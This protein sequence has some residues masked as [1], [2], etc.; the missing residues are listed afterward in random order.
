M[1]INSIP[2]SQY[3][4]RLPPQA[5]LKEALTLMLEK[6]VNHIAICEMNGRYVGILSTNAILHTLIPASAKVSGGLSSLR[7][8]GDAIRL[9]TAHLR[10][11]ETHQVGQFVNMSVPVMREDDPILEA[12]KLLADSST[13]LPVIDKNGKFV[14]VL[15]RR[16]L[17]AYLLANEG[18][19]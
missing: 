6:Q 13:P 12:A 14:G 2:I 7:F 17:L 15:S 8:T 19:N 10:D 1:P 11:L 3:G 5:S 16:A 9:L 18:E 4:L